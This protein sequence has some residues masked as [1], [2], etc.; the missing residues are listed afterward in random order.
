MVQ[1]LK[2]NLDE[3]GYGS[4]SLDGKALECRSISFRQIA[5]DLA[6]VT[7]RMFVKVDGEIMIDDL[8]SKGPKKW[9]QPESPVTAGS[10]KIEFDTAAAEASLD[11]LKKQIEAVIE[12]AQRA[13]EAGI[14]L[15]L[16]V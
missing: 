7:V 10:I 9:P 3:N 4:V 13:R 12:T 8:T 14:D 6:D 1:V 5:G 11:R 16:P 15:A 2:F